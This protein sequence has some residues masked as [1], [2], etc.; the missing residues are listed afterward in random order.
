[1]SEQPE[2]SVRVV[3]P[4]YFKTM[5][6]PVLEGRRHRSQRYGGFRTPWW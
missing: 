4:G 6:I 3:T 2:V 1:M 5:R